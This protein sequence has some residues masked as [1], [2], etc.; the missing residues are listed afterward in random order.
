MASEGLVSTPSALDFGETLRRARAAIADE[1]MSLVAEVD[2][3]AAAQAVGLTLRPATVLIFGNPR[4]GTLLMQAF[5]AV[6][7]DLPLKILVREDEAGRVWLDYN[8]PVWMVR[9]HGANLETNPVLGA[10][11]TKLD[12]VALKATRP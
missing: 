5:L 7:I 8:D 10:M 6:A 4:A 3:A 12:A 9:R 1:G 11:R 2:H